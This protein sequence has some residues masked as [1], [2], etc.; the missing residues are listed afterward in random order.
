MRS[1]F[2]PPTSRPTSTI[3]RCSRTATTCAKSEPGSHTESPTSIVPS[4]GRTPM[5]VKMPA[6]L[7]GQY[8]LK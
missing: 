1:Y 5:R 7:T 8:A 2:T 4:L 6:S 3:S